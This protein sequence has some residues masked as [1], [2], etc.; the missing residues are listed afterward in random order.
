MNEKQK[1]VLVSEW[2][3]VSLVIS[4]NIIINEY[5]TTHYIDKIDYFYMKDSEGGK[6]TAIIL[7][8]P[9]KYKEKNEQL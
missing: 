5:K 9:L 6:C 1:L 3:Y 7:L 2:G 8:S 4:I